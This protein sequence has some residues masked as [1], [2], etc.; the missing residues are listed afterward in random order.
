MDGNA[1]NKCEHDFFLASK[2]NELRESLGYHCRYKHYKIGTL[3]CRKC[4]ET[5]QVE[6]DVYATQGDDDFKR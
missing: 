1:T 5:K 6:L 3:I 4:G 2:S